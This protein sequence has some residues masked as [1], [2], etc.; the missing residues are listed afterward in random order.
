MGD[1]TLF[2]ADFVQT[3]PM[4]HKATQILQKLCTQKSK[5]RRH[6]KRFQLFNMRV[7]VLYLST[8]RRICT[9]FS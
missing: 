4:L 1:L 7:L 9:H 8:L 5:V 6:I 2:N 3:L